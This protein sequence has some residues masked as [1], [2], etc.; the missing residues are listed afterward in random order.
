MQKK[1]KLKIKFIG[2]EVACA[3]SPINCKGC[4]DEKNCETL[5]VIYNPYPQRDIINCFNNS[6][7][8][9]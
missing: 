8:R 3:K 1:I 4:K 5:S 9:R 2:S 6:E 7:K